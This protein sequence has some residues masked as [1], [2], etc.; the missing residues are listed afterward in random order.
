MNAFTTR[1]A[2]S[3]TAAL[4]ALAPGLALSVP[5][6][7]TAEIALSPETQRSF[8]GAVQG[9]VNACNAI[10]GTADFAGAFVRR[11]LQGLQTRLVRAGADRSLMVSIAPN[12]P[13]GAQPGSL[14]RHVSISCAGE[15]A[16]VCEV[17]LEFT[18]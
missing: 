6:P 11:D 16:L 14:G 8:D 9:V 3:G 1:L 18:R 5:A 7:A 17:M 4:L 12:V 10:C 2:R 13:G 15:R